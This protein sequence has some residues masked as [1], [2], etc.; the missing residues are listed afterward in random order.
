MLA[1]KTGNARILGNWRRELEE[2]LGPQGPWKLSPVRP[3]P[4]SEG[5]YVTAV[6]EELPWD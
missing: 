2:I 6:E 1:V 3:T 4:A 5:G